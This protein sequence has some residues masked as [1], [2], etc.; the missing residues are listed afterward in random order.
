MIKML[1]KILHH[2]PV[3]LMKKKEKELSCMVY[4]IYNYCYAMLLL[5]KLLLLDVVNKLTVVW[6]A[7]INCNFTNECLVYVIYYVS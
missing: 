3:V 1:F 5:R 6:F 2:S 7:E 4:K